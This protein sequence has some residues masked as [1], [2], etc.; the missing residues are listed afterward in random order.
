MTGRILLSIFFFLSLAYGLNSCRQSKHV[1]EGSYLLKKNKVIVS[2]SIDSYD[3]EEVIKQKPNHKS[4]VFF[5]LK[6]HVF[7]AIDSTKVANK[8]EKKNEKLHQKNKE[9]KAKNIRINKAR[10]RKALEAGDSLYTPK[11][12]VLK[13]TLEPRKF[14]REWLKYEV[15]EPPV[16]FDSNL[17]HRSVDQIKKYM[18]ARGYYDAKVSDST[19]LK[20][21]R[22]IN[23]IYEIH[24]GK[25][26][27]VD[28]VYIVGD[29][30]SVL[31]TFE[32]FK[33][34]PAY[35]LEPP[36]V[37]DTDLLDD[38]RELIAKHQRDDAKYGFV[39]SYVT[40][41]ADT[42]INDHK[43]RL[44]IVFNERYVKDPENEENK[45][46]K[47]FGTTYVSKVV[48]HIID[49]SYL[50][51]NYSYY[52]DLYGVSPKNDGYLQTFDTLRFDQYHPIEKKSDSIFR[53]AEFYYNGKLIVDPMLIEYCNFLENAN[54]YKEYYLTRSY[55]R[56]VELGI[57]QSIKP[58]L[59]ELPGKNQVEVHYYLV[60]AKKQSF[61]YETKATN[62]NGFLGLAAS[63]N[64][65]NKNLFGGGEK[66]T[67]SFGGGF[68]S[69]PTVFSDA[70]DGSDQN[71]GRSLNTFEF[72]PTAKLEIPGIRPFLH[73]KKLSKRHYPQTIIST[74]YS[75]QQREDFNRQLLQLNYG[76]KFNVL[77]KQVVQLGFPLLSSIQY[78]NLDKTS[79]FQQRLDD[80]N[81]LF[82][83]NTYSDQFIWKDFRATY[84]LTNKTVTKGNFIYYYDAE[85]DIAGM[86]LRALTQNKPVNADGYKEF[87]GVRYSE[88]IR[89]DNELKI[90][91]TFKNKRSLNFKVN[92]GAGLPL[93]NNGTSLPFDYSFFGGGAN[94]N[95]GWRARSL[96]PG[97][98]KYYIDSTRTATQAGDIRIGGSA[99]YRF[100]LGSSLRGA[101]FVDAGNIWTINEDTN[102]VGSQFTADWYNQMGIAGGFGLRLDLDFFVIRFD[103]GIPLR[104]PALPKEAR[105]IWQSREPFFDE[106]KDY[107]G[108]DFI[109]KYPWPFLPHFHLGIGYPF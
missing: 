71:N 70:L 80:L 100:P 97:T 107:Y 26:Y 108:E 59:I 64:Y 86:V 31:S 34:D 7:N 35:Q 40:F 90:Y 98:Y 53:I 9:L 88:F 95:R 20:W 101:L 74:A 52:T 19:K 6:L 55:S 50:E 46:L 22:K 13:D 16:V 44:G 96:G 89:L 47:K 21:G 82:L 91:Q 48:F 42:T 77:Q 58:Q 67:L 85:F 103:M 87:V 23:V 78:V 18:H 81:D 3:I 61:G 56:L 75:I 72:G 45:I 99:E 79:E 2:D 73:Y 62:S 92:F 104:N 63:V 41:E 4:L 38:Q 39:K 33:K 43:V 25:P 1:P 57:F 8:R 65:K 17:M 60:P 109:S 102:R 28:S 11:K 94:D 76:F 93:K 36:F 15:G 24:A 68:E 29:N 49:T 32:R 54:Y 37:F 30:P 12:L 69:Q 83:L 14:F 66:F 10:M 84:E 51:K 105:W 106:L 5:K 27:I